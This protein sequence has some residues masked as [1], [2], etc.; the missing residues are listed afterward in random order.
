VYVYDLIDSEVKSCVNTGSGSGVETVDEL[1]YFGDMLSGDGDAD[2]AENARIHSGCFMYRS[3]AS[4]LTVKD[5]SLLLKGKVYDACVL[6]Y[7][8][9]GSEMWSLKRERELALHMQK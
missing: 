6:S 5:V 1:C 2:A 3:L 8:P 7:M 9:H 4:F